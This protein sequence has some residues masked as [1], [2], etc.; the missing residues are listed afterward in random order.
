MALMRSIARG[1]AAAADTI[2]ASPDLTR[3]ALTGGATRDDAASWYL[4]EIGHYVYAGDTLLHVAAAAYRANLVRLLVARGAPVAAKNRRGA[5]PLHYA[6]DGGPNRSTWNPLAQ[7]ATVTCLIEAGANP[8][9]LD[10]SGVAPLH[11]AVR[12][13]CTAA[14]RALLSSGA[15]PNLANKSGS[16]PL[17]LATLTTGKGGSGSPEARREQAEILCLL[18]E[19]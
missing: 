15:N 8:S 6:A 12:S 7:A 1:D 18:R 9:A 11:R 17:E 10:K 5:E 13:R 14:V 4:S 19:R 16:T 2:A 3:R